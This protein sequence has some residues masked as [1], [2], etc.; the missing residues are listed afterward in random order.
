MIKTLVKP[1]ND[2]IYEC[3]WF[4]DIYKGEGVKI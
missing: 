4:F 2:N 1:L 3:F